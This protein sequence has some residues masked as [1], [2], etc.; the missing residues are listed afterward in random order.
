MVLDLK[1]LNDKVT[2]LEG[3]GV[4]KTPIDIKSL[5][6]RIAALETTSKKWAIVSIRLSGTS[7]PI[8]QE[9]LDYNFVVI[10]GFMGAVPD[11]YV[12]WQRDNGSL[13]VRSRHLSN[14]NYEFNWTKSGDRIVPSQRWE[15]GGAV[16]K[17]LFYK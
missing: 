2:E 15:F 1:T 6:D 5:A 12:V 4:P 10:G 7:Y 17:V 3:G 11:G 14:D 8:P 13:N 9:Y 16:I